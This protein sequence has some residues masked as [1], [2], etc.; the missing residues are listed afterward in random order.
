MTGPHFNGWLSSGGLSFES[1]HDISH[2]SHVTWLLERAR[3][4]QRCYSESLRYARFGHVGRLFNE[5]QVGRSSAGARDVDVVSHSI[6][7][8]LGGPNTVD[9]SINANYNMNQPNTNR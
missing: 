5:I 3:T 8:Y 2:V 1:N 7:V 4:P 6:A 9:T